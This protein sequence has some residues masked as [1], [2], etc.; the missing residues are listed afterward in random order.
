LERGLYQ[1]E[2]AKRIG[3][4]EMTIV[5][6]EKDRT[7]PRGERLVRLAGELGVELR[8]LASCELGSIVW[9]FGMLNYETAR[10]VWEGLQAT[11]TPELRRVLFQAGV[12]YARL[13]ADWALATRGGRDVAVYVALC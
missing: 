1:V 8:E 13:R 2:F 3:V 6:W 9:R 11:R 7:V 4:D 12:R 5:N 10:V